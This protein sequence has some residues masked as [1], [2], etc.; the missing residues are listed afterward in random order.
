RTLLRQQFPAG[1]LHRLGIANVEHIG[2]EAVIA[3]GERTVEARHLAAKPGETFGHGAPDAPPRPGHPDAATA[4]I[5]LMVHL[6]ALTK[7]FPPAL[8][9]AAD[10]C[11]ESCRS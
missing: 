6:S 1:L 7:P 3:F 5:H 9:A 8:P 11:R 10:G 2:R 4:E